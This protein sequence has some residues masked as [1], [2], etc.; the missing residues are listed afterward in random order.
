[1]RGATRG[2]A[3]AAENRLRKVRLFTVARDHIN[4]YSR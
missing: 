1:V 2:L 4:S 3:M